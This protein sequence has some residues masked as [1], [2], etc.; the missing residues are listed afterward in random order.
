MLI[1]V[2]YFLRIL[3]KIDID[4]HF[5]RNQYHKLILILFETILCL[6]LPYNLHL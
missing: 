6:H 5:Q 3:K 4:F 1:K 2:F